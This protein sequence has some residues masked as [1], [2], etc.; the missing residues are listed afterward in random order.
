MAQ[1]R[2]KCPSPTSHG[3]SQTRVE[4]LTVDVFPTMHN[5]FSQ[6]HLPPK[7]G[8]YACFQHQEVGVQ[9]APAT[10]FF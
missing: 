6:S 7:T 3:L 8:I 2:L 9:G 4:T 5:L 1:M 10:I